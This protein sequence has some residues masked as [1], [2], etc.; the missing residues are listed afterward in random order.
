MG[1]GGTRNGGFQSQW[2][3]LTA[4]PSTETGGPVT[5]D[6]RH[7]LYLKEKW[8]EELRHHDTLCTVPTMDSKTNYLPWK[9][10][11]LGIV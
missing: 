9:K 11:S 5:G 2:R 7:T 4:G 10:I 1:C 3:R 6:V 8:P